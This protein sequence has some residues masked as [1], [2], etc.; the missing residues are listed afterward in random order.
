MR[1]CQRHMCSDVMVLRSADCWTNH[2]LL[3]GQLRIRVPMKPRLVLRKRFEVGALK[4]EK[5]CSRFSEK[6]SERVASKWQSATSTAEKWEVIRDW[7][8]DVGESVLGWETTRQPDW[9]KESISVLKD[10]INKRNM[11]FGRLRSGKVSD[12]QRYVA[13]RRIVA[14]AVKK[15]KNEWLHKKAEEVERGLLSGHTGGGCWRSMKEIQKG[16]ARMRLVMN[17]VVRKSSGEV[18]VGRGEQLCRWNEHFSKMPNHP[19]DESLDASPSDDEVLEALAK[20]K[21][22]KAGGKNELLP[23]MW[24]CCNAELLEYLMELFSK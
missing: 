1:Q 14:G 2:K 17:R 12:H 23:E 7:L 24:K 22:G 10:G 4:D 6:V 18:C 3:Q 21:N 16:S 5:I 13:Q 8:K 20:L 19:V 15:A 9:F 11:L